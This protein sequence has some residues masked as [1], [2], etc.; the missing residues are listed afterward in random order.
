VP[1]TEAELTANITALE[2]AMSRHERVVQMADRSV[3]YNSIDDI[4][5][6]I[7]YFRD[8]LNELTAATATST[9]IVR[10]RQVFG[11]ASNGFGNRSTCS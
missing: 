10:R 7:S 9:G 1:Y 4:V 2:A 6:S 11:V 3:T 8:R 5:K